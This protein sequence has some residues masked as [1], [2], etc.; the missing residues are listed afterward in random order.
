MV[1][2]KDVG[3]ILGKIPLKKLLEGAPLLL[4]T[5]LSLKERF[6]HDTDNTTK[7]ENPTVESLHQNVI[8]LEKAFEKQTAVVQSLAEQNFAV[9][10]QIEELEQNNNKLLSEKDA[11]SQKLNAALGLSVVA[12]LI[13]AFL[14]FR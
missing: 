11:I 13:A 8:N 12:I 4:D 7:Q 14:L 5:I 2:A 6:K 10:R 9:I 3:K 1:N